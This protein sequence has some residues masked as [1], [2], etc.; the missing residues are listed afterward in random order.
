MVG[1]VATA[2]EGADDDVSW[3]YSAALDEVNVTITKSPVG[4]R[5]FAGIMD[6]QLS[7]RP[8]Y[9]SDTQE[10]LV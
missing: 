4:A 1:L 9:Y 10:S 7:S 3:L 6:A 5:Y 8:P 2:Q